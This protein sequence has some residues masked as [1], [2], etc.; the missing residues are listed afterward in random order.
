MHVPPA[1]SDAVACARVIRTVPCRHSSARAPALDRILICMKLTLTYPLSLHRVLLYHSWHWGL[2][3]QGE[4]L[5][6]LST[7]C[8]GRTLS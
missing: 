3:P 4:G 7:R 6:L 2:F 8:C 1:F 5:I